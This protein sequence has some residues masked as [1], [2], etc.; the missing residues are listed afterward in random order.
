MSEN[1]QPFK[2]QDSNAQKFTPIIPFISDGTRQAT[3]TNSAVLGKVSKDDINANGIASILENVFHIPP[4]AI[5]I[6]GKPVGSGGSASKDG[7]N[8]DDDNGDDGES[9][10]EDDAD[11][12]NVVMD[13]QAP[14]EDLEAELRSRL[15]VERNRHKNTSSK[16]YA[17]VQIV[18]K[19]PKS[20]SRRSNQPYS[21]HRG[22]KQR[23]VASISTLNDS[24]ASLPTDVV[25]L[26]NEST[27]NT[28]Y[29]AELQNIATKFQRAALDTT[30]S[31]H[32]I[33]DASNM[34]TVDGN[35]VDMDADTDVELDGSD[36]SEDV[37]S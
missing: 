15:G 18:H 29:P 7:S 17:H 9:D 5:S 37:S 12:T 1:S 6:D 27:Q 24:E 19:H 25:I 26:N 14:P 20:A 10:N 34:S 3:P 8:D 4:G 23:V 2:L 11:T 31:K 21:R 30:S 16:I 13:N 36:D 35:E 22:Y 32:S 28:V 33:G